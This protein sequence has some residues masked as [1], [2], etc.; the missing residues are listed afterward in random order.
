VLVRFVGLRSFSKMT[1]FDFIMTIAMGSLV[2][3][4]A[5]VTEIEQ[6]L[7]ACAAMAGLFLIQFVIAWIRKI[8]N[9]F[10]DIIQNQPLLLMRNGEII[11]EALSSSRVARGDLMS[12]LR[13]ASVTDMSQVR[14]VILETT[15]DVSVITGD[16]LDPIVLEGVQR[17]GQ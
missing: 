2:G 3:S 12:K 8:W 13:E 11:D 9:G 14:A 16:H 4:A 15:G 1:S 6:F 10:G 7:Q 17:V 5:R